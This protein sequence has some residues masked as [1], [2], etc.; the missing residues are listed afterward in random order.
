MMYMKNGGLIRLVAADDL[1]RFLKRGFV[2]F[3]A[4][5]APSLKQSLEKPAKKPS[6]RSKEG[7][8]HGA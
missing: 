4:S 1:P 5:G 3:E 6:E 8:P 7:K 2:P